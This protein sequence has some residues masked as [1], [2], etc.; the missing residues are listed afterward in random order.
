MS[1]DTLKLNA[2]FNRV[3]ENKMELED[4]AKAKA[5]LI[6]VFG[7]GTPSQH[8]LHQ[9]N[10]VVIEQAEIIYQ[11]KATDVL[12]ILAD[13][14]RRPNLEIIQ[15]RVPSQ[16]K[17]KWFWS[18]NGTSV[19]HTR[20]GTEGV[21]TMIPTKI[22]TGAYYEI[23]TLSEGDVNY[24][25]EIVN[26][27]ADAKI[28]MYFQQLSKL[29]KLAIT[30]ARIPAKN[31][32]TG[33]N[34][35]LA[36]YNKLV[37]IFVRAGQGRPVFVADSA[38]IDH[39]AF[40]QASDTTYKELLYDELKRSLVEDLSIVQIG[41]STAVDLVNP[42]VVGSGNTKT[43]LPVNEGYIFAGG[44]IKPFK[45]VEFGGITQYTEFDSDLEQIQIKMTQN[46]ALDFV[47]GELIGY[48]QDDSIVL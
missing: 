19:E 27:V 3:M 7:N 5:Y 37:N 28:E 13:V 30:D 16:H 24:F 10:Q 43:L 46:Y 21:R 4:D 23:L 32:L 8:E 2:M 15:Y 14:Q 45:L 18:A 17:A 48:V 1:F 40:Q 34:L 11:R 31:V 26:L 9:F 25:R 29:M 38:L 22:S 12:S 39:F 44:A 41:R 35:T 47:Q 20:I 36:Q 33:S 42:F 6:K